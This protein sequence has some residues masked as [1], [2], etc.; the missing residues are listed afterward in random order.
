MCGQF[1]VSEEIVDS[2][3]HLVPREHWEEIELDLHPHVIYPSARTIAVCARDQA[4]N[5]SVMTV[6]FASSSMNRRIFN[7]RLE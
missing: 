4:L 5:L 2:L 7:A 1:L 3:R 6:G